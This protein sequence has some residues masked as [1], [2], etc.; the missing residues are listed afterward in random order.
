MNVFLIPEMREE[1]F[2]YCTNQEK[3]QVIKLNKIIYS[4]I[5]DK[6][7]ILEKARFETHKQLGNY[8][9]IS[10][11]I[12]QKMSC[13]LCGMLGKSHKLTKWLFIIDDIFC[14]FKCTLDSLAYIH[15]PNEPDFLRCYY[16]NRQGEKDEIILKILNHIPNGKR[17]KPVR[18]NPIEIKLINAVV[19]RLNE[20]VVKLKIFNDDQT[21]E[22]LR[23][24]TKNNTKKQYKRF[25]SFI[26]KWCTLINASRRQG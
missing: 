14:I 21:Y 17:K 24:S 7:N 11:L 15:C 18:L 13:Y 19:D 1:I 16:N 20:I 12:V 6:N 22:N 23:L 26:E 2:K 9:C 3:S 10:H 5:S 4:S 25:C 8:I